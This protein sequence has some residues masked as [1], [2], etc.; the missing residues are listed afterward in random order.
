MHYRRD[1]YCSVWNGSVAPQRA[2][3]GQG[4][5]R[6]PRADHLD[7][8][9]AHLV[10][11]VE[12][13]AITTWS[14][15]STVTCGGASIYPFMHNVP[16]GLRAESFGAAFTALLVAAEDQVRDLLGVPDGFVVARAESPPG[17][18]AIAPAVR[19]RRPLRRP[20][21]TTQR[22]ACPDPGPG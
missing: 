11:L 13:A 9:P 19:H 10:I 20:P 16:L 14:R 3:P 17:C 4:P 18:R 22:D 15:R 8:V 5:E 6:D 2:A 12:L 21:F 7:A 1:L